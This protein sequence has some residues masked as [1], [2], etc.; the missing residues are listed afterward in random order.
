M[1][2]SDLKDVVTLERNTPTQDAGGAPID[3]WAPVAVVRG[4]IEPL[5]GR[6][7]FDAGRVIGDVSH[8]IRIRYRTGVTEAM[9]AVSADR[10]FNIQA[11][12]EVER[13]RQL[14]LMARELKA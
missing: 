13:R 4:A 1:R 5:S 11:V 9:R 3:N 12:L 6:E 10:I 2:P 7:F 14:H 8:R